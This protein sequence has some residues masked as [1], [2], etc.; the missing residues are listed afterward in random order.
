MV[1]KQGKQEEF[2]YELHLNPA[3]PLPMTVRDSGRK[4]EVR[5]QSHRSHRVTIEIG[6]SSRPS[7]LAFEPPCRTDEISPGQWGSCD[8]A[9]TVIGSSPSVGVTVITAFEFYGMP[10]YTSKG[11]R[12]PGRSRQFQDSYTVGAVIS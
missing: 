3:Q 6:V 5:Y 11:R 9:V 10:R 7:V 8:F 12:L 1:S 4:H 2:D